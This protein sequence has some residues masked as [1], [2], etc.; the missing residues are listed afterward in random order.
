[1]IN[2]DYEIAIIGAGF[3]GL[4]LAIRLQQEGYQNF[5]IFERAAI[6][7]GTWRDNTYPG[8]ACDVPSHLYSFSFEPNPNW[9]REYSPQPEILNYILHCK[10]K[11]HLDSHIRYNTTIAQA[12]FDEK[13]GCWELKNQ[14]GDIFTAR[15]LVSAIGPLNVPSIPKIKGLETFEGASFHS[16][17]WDGKIDLNGKKVAVIGTGASAIQIVPNIAPKVAE[18]YLFQRTAPWILPKNDRPISKF[19]QNLF[20]K[21]PFLQYLKRTAYY[22]FYEFAGRALFSDNLVR[23]VTRRMAKR[24]L[25]NSIPDEALRKKLTP[26]YEIGCK[27]RLPS[28][29]FYPALLRK[30]VHLVTDNVQEISAKGVMDDKGIFRDVDVIIWATGFYVADFGKRDISVLGRNG[31]NLFAEWN[32]K[33]PEGYYGTCVSGFPNMSLILGPN[34][35][36]GHTS[37]LHIIESQINYILDYIKNIKNL[38]NNE[39]LDVKPKAQEKYNKE[40]HEK[41]QT[42]VWSSGGC[43]SWYLHESGRNSTLW[44]G[45]TNTFRNRTKKI[46]LE[47]FEVVG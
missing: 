1:M 5:I 4:G 10:E 43:N 47:D 41:L 26:N 29:D 31:R 23:T 46:I 16:S 38:P 30:N 19:S 21:I 17:E 42:M 24:H 35:G 25:R 13:R 2:T 7:G 39:F 28:D 34:T 36:L 27:R 22:W 18:L 12:D 8:C 9:S 45:H 33:G 32:E 44:P 14:H 3:G 6:A 20:Q 15:I 40:I 11:H 37:Q